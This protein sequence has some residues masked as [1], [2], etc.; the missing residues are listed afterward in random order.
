MNGVWTPKRAPVPALALSKLPPTARSEFDEAFATPT[1]PQ[2]H[3]WIAAARGE[4]LVVVAPRHSGGETGLRYAAEILRSNGTH[5]ELEVTDEAGPGRVLSLRAPDVTLV[6]AEPSSRSP[7]LA[8]RI[9]EERGRCGLIDTTR[10]ESVRTRVFAPFRDIPNPDADSIAPGFDAERR[11]MMA[12]DTPVALADSDRAPLF[13]F[14][15]GSCLL[16]GGFTH[17]ARVARLATAAD[18]PGHE[19]PELVFF[20]RDWRELLLAHVIADRVRRGLLDE[21]CAGEGAE[22]A[23]VAQQWQRELAGDTSAAERVAYRLVAGLSMNRGHAMAVLN[24]IRSET[25]EGSS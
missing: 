17:S 9:A 8:D 20:A 22:T 13:P 7:T 14:G 25:P 11:R 16:E 12:G 3:L 5:G 18:G 15:A 10:Y 6:V 21:E 2:R 19:E 4:S 1:L 24:G 23:R